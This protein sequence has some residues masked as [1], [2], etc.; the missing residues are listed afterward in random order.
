MSTPIVSGAVTLLLEKHSSL[1][2]NTVKLMLKQSCETM[3]FPRNQQ[4]WGL[5]NIER[6]LAISPS[7]EV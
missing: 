4:G 2:P 5:L 1:C 3:E 6:L 7:Q